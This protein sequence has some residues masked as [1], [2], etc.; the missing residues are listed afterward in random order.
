M[1]IGATEDALDG[2]YRKKRQ[3]P[4][5]TVGVTVRLCVWSAV[6]FAYNDLETVLEK[7]KQNG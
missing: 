1:P 4:L 6:G 7:A 2:G 3:R 5:I